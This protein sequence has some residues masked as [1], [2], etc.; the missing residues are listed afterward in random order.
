MINVLGPVT[1]EGGCVECEPTIGPK[2]M[3]CTSSS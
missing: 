2:T 1:T 3:T